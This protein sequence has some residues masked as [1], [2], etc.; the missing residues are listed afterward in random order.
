MPATYDKLASDPPWLQRA[1]DEL[2]LGVK[3]IPGSGSNPRI[4]A[5][6]RATS[7]D[8]EWINDSTAWCA[9]FTN[10][11]FQRSTADFPV[12]LNGT[13]SA[14]AKSFKLYG[15][16]VPCMRGAVA[17]F[18]RPPNPDSGHVGFVVGCGSGWV[19]IL[20]GNQSD[21]VTIERFS[22][23]K[24]IALR[25]PNSYPLPN[26]NYP[27]ANGAL[28]ETPI[29]AK[30]PKTPPPRPTRQPAPPQRQPGQDSSG[31]GVVIVAVIAAVAAL[32]IFGGDR[33]KEVLERI[34]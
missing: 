31:A 19:D 10:Y 9:G 4:E 26:E 13:M 15:R 27:V 8:Q 30:P 16:P 7:L 34:F 28:P 5:Y 32:I 14:M 21:A 3:E 11:C 2:V 6:L 18:D 23:D 22:T 33:L 25:W 1:F 20:G 17:V 29:A 24:L 12:P